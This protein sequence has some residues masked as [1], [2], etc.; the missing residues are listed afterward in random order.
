MNVSTFDDGQPEEFLALLR[1]F[2][3]SIGGTV[4]TTP[5]VRINYLY[6]ILCG[7]I[8]RGFYLI[9]LQGNTTN[10]HLNHITE[11]LLEYFFS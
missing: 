1:N 9:S 5:T 11:S 6:K 2:K 7:K 3:I 4:K 8:L 10:N